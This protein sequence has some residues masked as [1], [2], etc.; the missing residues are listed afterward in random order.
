MQPA[1]QL[2]LA[3]L[4]RSWVD[5]YTASQATIML[6]KVVIDLLAAELCEDLVDEWNTSEHALRRTPH[7]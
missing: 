6:V 4:Q 3:L 1:K 7:P 2:R 5:W